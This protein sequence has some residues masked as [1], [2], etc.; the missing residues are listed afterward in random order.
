MDGHDVLRQLRQNKIDT[1]VIILTGADDTENRLKSFG[2]G[3]DDY[4]SKPFHHEEL[5]ARIH[6]IIRR[7]KGHSQ[8]IIKTDLIEINLDAMTVEVGGK[9][10]FLTVKEYKVLELLS[11]R[12]GVILSKETFLNHLYGGMD[13]P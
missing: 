12:K 8:S 6:A 3:S 10:L 11:L 9:P 13:E 7:S 4:I 2:I 1:P 5:T